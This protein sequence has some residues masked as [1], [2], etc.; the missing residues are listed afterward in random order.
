MF[1]V[2]MEMLLTLGA[3][4]KEGEMEVGKGKGHANEEKGLLAVWGRRG[5]SG[6]VDKGSCGTKAPLPC[7]LVSLSHESVES[8]RNPSSLEASSTR[9][10]RA[11]KTTNYIVS[12]FLSL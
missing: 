9:K 6:G 2:R 11:S 10:G 5:H 12:E 1:L 3:S 4:G 7:L 8:I